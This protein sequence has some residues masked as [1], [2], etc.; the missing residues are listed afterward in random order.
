[1][2]TTTA[3][4]STLQIRPI[5][6]P[7]PDDA[8]ASDNTFGTDR[9]LAYAPCRSLGGRD[10]KTKSE[11]SR[12]A[13]LQGTTG[14]DF[15]VGAATS[16]ARYWKTPT[17]ASSGTA[18]CRPPSITAP[19]A[20]TAPNTTAPDVLAAVSPASDRTDQLGRK[21]STPR[22]R[23]SWMAL[24]GGPLGSPS[25]SKTDGRGEQLAVPFNRH[26][27][28]SL[29]L[30]YPSSRRAARSAMYGEVTVPDEVARVMVRHMTTTH[31]GNSD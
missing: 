20:S 29:G 31:F 22:S 21:S 8:A 13:G 15:D 18:R 5:R 9:T 16:R 10:R 30:G 12:V 11:A 2:A 1:M 24:P 17:R 27:A 14:W 7:R 26:P 23:A 28:T 3:A 19:I 6:R 4:C 25:A